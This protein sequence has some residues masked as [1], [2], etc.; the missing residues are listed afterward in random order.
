MV[1]VRTEKWVHEGNC[2]AHK[3]EHVYFVKGAIPGELVTIEILKSYPKY[4]LGRVIQVLEP[5]PDRIAYD[6]KIANFC[7]G[8]S[9]RHIPYSLEMK[10][11]KQL[12]LEDWNFRGIEFP[13]SEIEFISEKEIGYR[14]N[15][16]IKKSGNTLGFYAEHSNQILQLPENGCQNLDPALNEILK[17]T[18]KIELSQKWRLLD[19]PYPY[20]IETGLFTWQHKIL[21]IPKNGF[22]QINSALITPWLEKLS[23]SVESPTK[24]LELFCGSGLISIALSEKLGT[25]LGLEMDDLSVQYAKKNS[26]RNGIK[27]LSFKRQ[28]LYKDPVRETGFDLLIVN[29]PRNGLGKLVID[30]IQKEKPNTILYSSC[31]YQT[32]TRDLNFILKASYKI[33]SAAIFDFFPRTPY[34]ET[35]VKLNSSEI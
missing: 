4:S 17:D 33:S 11:K 2:I 12:F 24:T 22:F 31:N 27:N 3:D 26:K 14:N 32:L 21:E 20:D 9:F 16:Q 25:A 8:C 6:C 7:G 10:L 5:S 19:K 1:T 23:H 28:N 15:F 35:L 18:H 34:F 29:P 30:W 13:S